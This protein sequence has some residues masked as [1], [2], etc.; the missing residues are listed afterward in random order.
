MFMAASEEAKVQ[1]SFLLF[2][3]ELCHIWIF[4][5]RKR[6]S[7]FLLRTRALRF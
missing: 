5:R 2:F 4:V 7:K 3:G 1:L 6:N